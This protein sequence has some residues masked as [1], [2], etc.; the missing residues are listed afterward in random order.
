M[1]CYSLRRARDL[2]AEVLTRQ[3]GY[4]RG[5]SK[6]LSSMG[7]TCGHLLDANSRARFCWYSVPPS[8]RSMNRS[9]SASSSPSGSVSLLRIVMLDS[10]S[11]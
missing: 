3:N 2:S 10:G 8:G 6:I 5:S 7:S 11:I 9:G 4:G 1:A